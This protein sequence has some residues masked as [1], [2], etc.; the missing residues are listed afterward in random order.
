MS[1]AY[2]ETLK[3]SN[4]RCYET[5]RL[6]L[7]NENNL[8]V[9]TGHNGAGKTNILEALSFLSP[10]RGLRRASLGEVTRIGSTSPWAVSAEMR[11]EFGPLKIGTGLRDD[12][13]DSDGPLR[14]VVRV[15]GEN[16]AGPA[17]LAS[18]FSV[19]WLTPQM[20]RLFI[21]GASSRRRFLDR[22]MLGMYPDHGRQVSAYE[23]AMQERSR[24]LTEKGLQADAKWLNALEARMAEHGV[25]VAAA[26]IAFAS[27]LV[28]QIEASKEGAFP[29]AQ[30]A[31]DG[32]VEQ[33]LMQAPATAVE[34]AERERLKM[35]RV[36]DSR[37]GRAGNGPHK[38]DLRV[39]HM[40]KAMPAELCSTGEQKALLIGVILANAKLKAASDGS[41]PLMLLDE[42]AAHL[43]KDRR[44]GLFDELIALDSQCWLTGT[45]RTLFEAL[46]GRASFYKVEDGNVSTQSLQ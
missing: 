21:E 10:G 36:A 14:R 38:C 28:G 24:L 39:T 4:F 5:A 32:I 8:V 18:Q 17:V 45:D 31:L 42:V 12:G 26:R 15:D 13:Q 22:L 34:D 6:D 1:G 9:L 2:V 16:V 40:E 11:G 3:L 33:A 7:G 20:D 43:D 25:A 30:L 44:A 19:S 35:A 37:N 41:A 27:Q 46:E 29:K 23:R